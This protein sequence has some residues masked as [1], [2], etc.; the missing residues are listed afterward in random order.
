MS[1]EN[2]RRDLLAADRKKGSLETEDE[3]K[4][5]RLGD[6]SVLYRYVM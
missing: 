3:V 4:E 1:R 6:R 2:K 5:Q